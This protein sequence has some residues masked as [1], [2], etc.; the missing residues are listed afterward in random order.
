MQETY[1][2]LMSV[3]IKDF[4]EPIRQK[5]LLAPAVFTAIFPNDI[6]AI[7]AL[8]QQLLNRLK[9]IML[10]FEET[11][12]KEKEINESFPKYLRPLSLA[13]LL[14]LVYNASKLMLDY[15]ASEPYRE[16]HARYFGQYLDS[17]SILGKHTSANRKL[18]KFLNKKTNFETYASTI[19]LRITKYKS[20]IDG[21]WEHF[22]DLMKK[23][24]RPLDVPLENHT[25]SYEGVEAMLMRAKTSVHDMAQFCNDNGKELFLEMKYWQLVEKLD[26]DHGGG[27]RRLIGCFTNVPPSTFEYSSDKKFV[28]MPSDSDLYVC[29]DCVVFEKKDKSVHR[30]YLKGPN[31]VNAEVNIFR[32]KKEVQMSNEQSQCTIRVRDETVFAQLANLIEQ[33]K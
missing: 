33:I 32:E 11:K 29:N 2:E 17:V 14:S 12:K 15:S 3:F 9:C 4:M 18:E 5:K 21:M 24:T 1:V 25:P 6:L 13:S 28:P 7:Y 8:N 20:I 26:G 31:G 16:L 10:P 27:Q 22:R 23:E 30:Q 19:A